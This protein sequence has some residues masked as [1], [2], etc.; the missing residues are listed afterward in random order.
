MKVALV[1]TGLGF[2]GAERI[3][4]ALA[5]DLKHRG[6]EVLVVAT[7]RAG[8]IAASLADAGITVEILGIRHAFD[9]L[10]PVALARLLHR[11]ETQLV[12]SHLAVAD[13]TV[14]LATQLTPVMARVSTV[15]NPGVELSSPKRAAWYAALSSFHRVLA[16]SEHVRDRLPSRPQT[17]VLHPSLISGRVPE[18]TR[19]EARLALGLAE[20]ELVV[21]AVGRL[22][23]I[24]GF[25]LLIETQARLPHPKL[26]FVLI[27]DGPERSNLEGRGL[28]LIGERSDAASLLAAADIVVCP[29][30]SEG[31]PQVPLHAQAAGIPVVATAVGGQSEV[32]LDGQTGLLV[33]PENP[34][35]LA[36]AIE[37]L[38]GDPAL[39]RRLGAAGRARLEERQLY[40][41]RMFELTLE[42]YREARRSAS[43]AP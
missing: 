36:R 42:A 13:I 23:P 2:G 27:G 30:R 40:R 25:D 5:E 16:V 29:S 34:A 38:I 28:R 10:A 12:H 15:H 39:R 7:T 14:A 19:S 32:V 35:A 17:R 37:R 43:G 26:R 31:F 1:T 41:H 33:G 21:M 24:K 20:D 3:V 9:L 6:A 22:H 8:P 11:H 4:Q 18:G